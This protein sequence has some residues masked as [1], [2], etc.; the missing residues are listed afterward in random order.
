MAD[1]PWLRAVKK[2]NGMYNKDYSR[3]PA[4]DEAGATIS[5]VAT[6]LAHT[7]LAGERAM[8]R[9]VSEVEMGR[10][11]ATMWFLAWMVTAPMRKAAAALKRTSAQAVA[12]QTE[13]RQRV[14]IPARD[15][16]RQSGWQGGRRASGGGGFDITGGFK[17]S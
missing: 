16:A 4:M 17:E 15:A 3:L 7:I 6:A 14:I 13:L 8:R 2:L 10:P 12:Y 5:Y 1:H 9:R 11:S